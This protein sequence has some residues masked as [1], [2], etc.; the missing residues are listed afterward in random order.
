MDSAIAARNPSLICRVGERVP[1]ERDG[2][3]GCET[4]LGGG[5]SN[6]EADGS[7]ELVA[8][9]EELENPSARG[10]ES[11]VAGNVFGERRRWKCGRLIGNP[12]R[13][14]KRLRP[15]ERTPR[16]DLL[17]VKEIGNACNRAHG[18]ETALRIPGANTGVE[19]G[20]RQRKK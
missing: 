17:A 3:F 13:A 6:R 18:I 15:V 2:L 12:E 5:A 9:C 8:V 10:A 1:R 11:A 7:T 20:I 19:D 4:G 14:I 16:L